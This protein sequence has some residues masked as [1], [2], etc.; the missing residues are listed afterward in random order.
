MIEQCFLNNIHALAVRV[1]RD[2]PN[3]KQTQNR[4]SKA[5]IEKTYYRCE[6]RR[7]F[8]V[9]AMV[10]TTFTVWAGDY[11][12]GVAALET[13]DSV[14]ALTSFKSAANKGDPRAQLLLGNMYKDGVLF[15]QDYKEAAH[16]YSLAAKQGNPGAMLFLA[17]LLVLGKG[18]KQ[19]FVEAVRLLKLSSAQGLVDAQWFLGGMYQKGHG[20][21]KDFIRAHMWFNLSAAQGDES[22]LRMREQLAQIMT[23]QQIAQAQKLAVECLTRNYKGCD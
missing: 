12:D 8:L 14:K 15:E 1:A 2:I 10:M 4:I 3:K 5:V 19:N 18:V 22:A 9:L 6:M 11:E 17:R 16:W 13:K 20:V 7:L 21:K 23:Q